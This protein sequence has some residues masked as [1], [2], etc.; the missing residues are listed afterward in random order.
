MC[1][2]S[3]STCAGRIGPI[4]KYPLVTI[5]VPIMISVAPLHEAEMQIS[6]Q[7]NKAVENFCIALSSLDCRD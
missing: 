2:Q 6:R 7:A 5:A 3:N 4:N 1:G